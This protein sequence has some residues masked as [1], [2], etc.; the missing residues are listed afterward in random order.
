MIIKVGNGNLADDVLSKL[1]E[2]ESTKLR[3]LRLELGTSESS[4]YAAIGSTGDKVS[5]P[6]LALLTVESVLSWLEPRSDGHASSLRLHFRNYYLLHGGAYTPEDARTRNM[7]ARIR[8]AAKTGLGWNTLLDWYTTN[9]P[10]GRYRLYQ[11]DRAKAG[12]Y[13]P[14]GTYRP[15]D[16]S[17]GA[18]AEGI[19]FAK[20]RL[21]L[22]QLMAANYPATDA[23]GISVLEASAGSDVWYDTNGNQR[24]ATMPTAVHARGITPAG[25]DRPSVGLLFPWQEI[26]DK[27]RELDEATGDAWRYDVLSSV[28]PYDEDGNV[29]QVVDLSGTNV[30]VVGAVGSGK[31]TFAHMAAAILAD[32]G[33]TSCWIMP[34]LLACHDVC[35]KAQAVGIS[36]QT[37]FSTHG[38]KRAELF[39]N[40]GKDAWM[41]GK[42][43]SDPAMSAAFLTACPLMALEDDPDGFPYLEPDDEPCRRVH[44]S[45]G[46]GRGGKPAPASTTK[47]ICPF[48]KACP[49]T[50]QWRTAETAQVLATTPAGLLKG[51]TRADGKV[52]Y[53]T[54]VDTCSVTFADEAESILASLDDTTTEEIRIHEF[55]RSPLLAQVQG[56]LDNSSFAEMTGEKVDVL[57]NVQRLRNALLEVLRVMG[58]TDTGN[59]KRSGAAKPSDLVGITGFK[60]ETLRRNFSWTTLFGMVD[61]RARENNENNETA[62]SEALGYQLLT[63][64]DAEAIRKLSVNSNKLTPSQS[65]VLRLSADPANETPYLL[66]QLGIDLSDE[67]HEA[68]GNL[69]LYEQR[70]RFILLVRE[71]QRIVADLSSQSESVVDPDLK[72][73]LTP[74]LGTGIRSQIEDLPGSLTQTSIAM[75]LANNDNEL[76]V[77]RSA[78]LGRGA[79]FALPKMNGGKGPTSVYMSGTSVAPSSLRNNVPARTALVLVAPQEKREVLAGTTYV[80]HPEAGRVSGKKDPGARERAVQDAAGCA[81][82]IIREVLNQGRHVLVTAGSYERCKAAGSAL[83]AMLDMPVTVAVRDKEASDLVA[84]MAG[85]LVNYEKIRMSDIEHFA[86][87]VCVAPLGN[88]ARAHNIIDHET[89]D[90]YFTDIVVLERMLSHPDSFTTD[91]QRSNEAS[92]E[93]LLAVE[94]DFDTK[95]L[96][97]IQRAAAN[98]VERIRYG[99]SLSTGMANMPEELR[100][101]VWASTC[102]DIIQLRGRASRVG[103][104]E[105]HHSPVIHLIDGSFCGREQSASPSLDDPTDFR[106]Q[107]ATFLCR[108]GKAFAGQ[109]LYEPDIFGMARVFGIDIQGRPVSQVVDELAAI[110][111]VT[112]E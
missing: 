91:V 73:L 89:G 70:L 41:T 39:V 15:T 5:N 84:G 19:P 51:R 4:P 101:D 87:Q 18:G 65:S 63:E 20:V 22:Y 97:D 17:S 99:E 68:L 26:L 7:T 46:R 94:G 45:K 104:G 77:S 107:F 74:F 11:V 54:I 1:D 112:K 44:A 79:L 13:T 82:G 40:D 59:P 38:D 23:P 106:V 52:T 71:F 8:G 80:F 62:M 16:G 2:D 48:A 53:Q 14:Y 78:L 93:R 31:T 42:A 12:G 37:L 28:T 49:T 108:A 76:V 10:L 61:P 75:R 110:V 47:H 81:A 32:R 90:S 88:V 6:Y 67:G 66:G 56:R 105:S 102:A 69:R 33:E 96:Y 3:N 57:Q 27:A 24:H 35:A 36:A 109:V 85:P 92:L 58:L 50:R 43:V 34:S 9:G 29:V 95:Q 86:G 25:H 111:H 30:S 103:P 83:A 60:E 100:D 98:N 21:H 72:D 55:L 64:D